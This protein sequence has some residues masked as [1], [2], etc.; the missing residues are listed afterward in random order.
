MVFLLVVAG[1]VRGF[2]NSDLAPT[3]GDASMD[4]ADPAMRRCYGCFFYG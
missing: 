2:V 1:V 4:C 3:S